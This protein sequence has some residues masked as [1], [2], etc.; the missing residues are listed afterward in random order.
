MWCPSVKK[1]DLL[2]LLWSRSGAPKLRCTNYLEWCH[3]KKK[4]RLLPL[5]GSR[6]AKRY[7]LLPFLWSRSG[8]PA[9]RCAICY[10]CFGLEVVP[11]CEDVRCVAVA[12]VSKWC[13]NAKKY[14]LL[15]LLRSRSGAPVVRS[16]ICC[17]CFRLEVMPPM[18]RCMVCCR[19]F[20]LEVVPPC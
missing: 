9:L 6:S 8:A 17:R 18:L 10:R 11:Q 19:C 5:L 2:P 14:H 15:P 4:Y 20:G 13:P 12:V 16:T 1:Y 7:D 3:K